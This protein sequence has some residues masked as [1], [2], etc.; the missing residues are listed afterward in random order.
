ML[1]TC[2]PH[3]TGVKFGICS[4]NY[5]RMTNNGL[6]TWYL[7]PTLMFNKSFPTNSLSSLSSLEELLVLCALHWM[8]LAVDIDFCL[9][10]ELWEA[11]QCCWTYDHSSAL[12]TF[13]IQL[14]AL[15][16]AILS[17]PQHGSFANPSFIVF[18]VHNPAADK[19]VLHYQ[20][21][22]QAEYIFHD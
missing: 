13:Q 1:T 18:Q 11:V 20:P 9:Y 17:A 7:P 19:V 16:L 14:L 2:F 12:F 6:K 15:S 10:P 5:V 22:P 8:V 3:E 4:Y 21:I